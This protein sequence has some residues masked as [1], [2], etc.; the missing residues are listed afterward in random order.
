MAAGQFLRIKVRL[1]KRKPLQRTW[2]FSTSKNPGEG[3]GKTLVPF[4]IRV[5]AGFLLYLWHPRAHPEFLSV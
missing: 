3:G 5:L 1:D 4:L 2:W